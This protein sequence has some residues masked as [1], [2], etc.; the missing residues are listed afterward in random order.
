MVSVME[1]VNSFY[2]LEV[3]VPSKF[4]WLRQVF[5]WPVLSFP[6]LSVECSRITMFKHELARMTKS[7]AP[8]IILNNIMCYDLSLTSYHLTSSNP[9]FCIVVIRWFLVLLIY[10]LFHFLIKPIT[11]Y[12]LHIKYKHSF[13]LGCPYYG[14]YL[15]T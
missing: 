10:P 12:A 6:A 4:I 13:N 1:F 7:I 3:V 2:T 5:V 8:V 14:Q 9:C 15:A 11:Y